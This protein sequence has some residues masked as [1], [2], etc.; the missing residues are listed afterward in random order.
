MNF[1]I[2]MGI[3]CA[4][5]FLASLFFLLF[6]MSSLAYPQS[7]TTVE[8]YPTDMRPPVR[9]RPVFV[10]GALALV[11]GGLGIAVFTVIF[12]P[13]ISAQARIEQLGEAEGIT[14][15]TFK[16]K[17]GREPHKLTFDDDPRNGWQQ[18]WKSGWQLKGTAWLDNQEEWDLD[19]SKAAG[20]IKFNA[21]RRP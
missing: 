3:F 11:T 8:V 13:E 10:Q 6:A 2:V 20:E 14:R 18:I 1:L 9:W 7:R 4:A 15:S 21:V 16:T 17:L 12:M 5:L 19:V